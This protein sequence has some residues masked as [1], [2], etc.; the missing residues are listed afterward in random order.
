M[1]NV[2][3]VIVAFPRSLHA[4]EALPH[5]DAVTTDDDHADLVLLSRGDNLNRVVEHNV[6]ELIV[7]AEHT[8]DVPV[9]SQLQVEALLHEL[10]Q[11]HTG[12][13]LRHAVGVG[14]DACSRPCWGMGGWGG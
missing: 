10:P 12:A 8:D 3:V 6:H 1:P 5:H 13:G 2:R 9:G 4:V 7:A 11:V 14:V